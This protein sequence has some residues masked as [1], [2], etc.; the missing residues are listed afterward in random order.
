MAGSIMS[1]LRNKENDNT[2]IKK[3]LH[4]AANPT[5]TYKR[6]KHLSSEIEIP[7]QHSKLTFSNSCLLATFN[8]KMVAI[9]KNLVAKNKKKLKGR[10]VH[11][12]LHIVKKNVKGRT[13]HDIL[14]QGLMHR[15][16]RF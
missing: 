11:D 2:V 5:L 7:C 16:A 3:I 15:T 1:G 13:L 8:W 6:L 10:T 4:T 12:I 14:H 9:K